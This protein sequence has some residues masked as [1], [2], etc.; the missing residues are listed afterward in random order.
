[1]SPMLS[2]ALLAEGVDR[3]LLADCWGV[4]NV[5]S[6]A[7]RGGWVE[8]TRF[9]EGRPTICVALLAE[10][11]DRNSSHPLLCIREA[12]ALLAE[13]VDRN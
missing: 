7:A 13:G 2:V 9:F 11:V 4:L 3:N 12:V 5:V 10:G 1:M 6:P 8:I